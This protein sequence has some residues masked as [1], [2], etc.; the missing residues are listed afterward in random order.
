MKKRLFGALAA[1]AIG[2]SVPAE[3]LVGASRD[4]SAYAGHVVLLSKRSA[5]GGSLCSGVVVAQDVLLTAAHCAPN[6]NDVRA[7]VGDAL[8]TISDVAVHPGYRADAAKARVKSIDLALVRLAQPLPS[9]FSPV[10]FSDRTSANVGETF[11]YVG[12]GMTN[13][14]APEQVGRLRAANIPTQA[15]LSKVLLWASDSANKGT[16]ACAGDSGGGVFDGNDHLIAIIDWATGS[17]GKRCGNLTQSALVASERA[18]I[19]RVLAGWR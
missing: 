12:F 15:P 4:G 14:A 5:H 7:V 9:S 6:R 13:E 11:T 10:T 8:R 2:A 16:G 18:W 19:D 17:G 3:A 1:C